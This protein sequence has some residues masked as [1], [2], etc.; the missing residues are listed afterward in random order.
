MGVGRSLIC[1]ATLCSPSCYSSTCTDSSAC[2]STFKCDLDCKTLRSRYRFHDKCDNTTLDQLRD[3]RFWVRPGETKAVVYDSHTFPRIKPCDMKTCFNLVACTPDD[4]GRFKAFVYNRSYPFS[5]SGTSI[6]ERTLI[7]RIEKL[8]GAED[9]FT[10]V[11]DPRESCI[12]FCIDAMAGESM[13]KTFQHWKDGRNHVLLW[14]NQW[15]SGKGKETRESGDA[16]AARREV[17]RAVVVLNSHWGVYRPNF[18]MQMPAGLGARGDWPEH[19]LG[20]YRGEAARRN[21]S[22]NFSD[23]RQYLLTF[24]GRSTL[25]PRPGHWHRNVAGR[26]HDPDRGIIMQVKCSKK[27]EYKNHYDYASLIFDSK[28]SYCPAGFGMYSHRLIEALAGGSIPVVPSGRWKIVLPFNDEF[29]WDNCVVW[30]NFDDEEEVRGFPS[31]LENVN[32]TEYQ[33]RRAVCHAIYVNA[34]GGLVPCRS[35]GIA[36]CDHDILTRAFFRTLHNR[37]ARART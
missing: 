3:H 32:S 21:S 8:Q 29:P 5:P 36:R 22:I 24:R 30:V 19:I 18:D 6:L 12:F 10:E 33:S 26:W 13:T 2:P 34:I 35:D 28:F 4:R 27:G 20:L 17:G 15:K 1:V 9:F 31:R 14:P 23:S 37:I 11:I 16:P 7:E 25:E